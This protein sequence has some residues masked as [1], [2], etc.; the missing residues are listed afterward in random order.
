M[1]S[2]VSDEKLGSVIETAIW[3]K[4]EGHL[5]NKAGFIKPAKSMSQI[6]G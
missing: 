1:R 5:I 3:R 4:E 2:G 6:G